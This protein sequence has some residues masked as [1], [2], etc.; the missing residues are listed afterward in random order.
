MHCIELFENFGQVI[1]RSKRNKSY[2]KHRNESI[3]QWI[4]TNNWFGFLK[5]HS[6]A[7]ILSG[8]PSIWFTDKKLIA[9]PIIIDIDTYFS[10]L[11][12][13]ITGILNVHIFQLIAKLQ[14]HDFMI[15][16]STIEIHFLIDLQYKNWIEKSLKYDLK[17]WAGICQMKFRFR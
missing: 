1:M 8:D 13:T 2:C 15:L 7:N 5:H 17:R 6:E 4:C 12:L 14:W 10:W 16:I 3:F 9:S 11:L